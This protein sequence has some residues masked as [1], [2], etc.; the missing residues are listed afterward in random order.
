MDINALLK[1]KKVQS[2]KNADTAAIDIHHH[3]RQY[4]PPNVDIVP[5]YKGYYRINDMEGHFLADRNGTIPLHRFVCWQFS[6]TKRHASCYHCGYVLPWKSSLTPANVHV[7]NVDHLDNDNSNNDPSNLVASCWWCN[8]NRSWAEEHP[9]FW[10]FMR[11]VFAEVPPQY[12]PDIRPFVNLA[13]PT[14]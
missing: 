12:R 11:K 3:V 5:S 8:T 1:R 4:L 7:I 13:K 10:A 9:Q 6:S 2:V 14:T